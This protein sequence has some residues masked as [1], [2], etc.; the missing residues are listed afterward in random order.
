[1]VIIL[2]RNIT[3]LNAQL[4]GNASKLLVPADGILHVVEGDLREFGLQKLLF[5]L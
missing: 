5:K 3:S 1:M 2:L 4:F